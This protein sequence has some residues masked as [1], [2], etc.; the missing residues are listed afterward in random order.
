M[1]TKDRITRNSTIKT[2][3]LLW[4]HHDERDATWETDAYLGE[5]YLDFY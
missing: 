3:K 1:D 4:S 5:V 2:Y